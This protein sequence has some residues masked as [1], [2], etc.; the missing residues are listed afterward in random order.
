MNVTY[1]IAHLNQRQLITTYVNFPRYCPAYRSLCWLSS[2]HFNIHSLSMEG[3]VFGEFV[4]PFHCTINVRLQRGNA[5][6]NAMVIKKK[7]HCSIR[8][9]SPTGKANGRVFVWTIHRFLIRF[10][11]YYRDSLFAPR[12]NQIPSFSL[13][14]FLVRS[15]FSFCF[16]D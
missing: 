3:K 11:I 6:Q 16:D 15:F 9:T 10:N 4:E 12:G 7:T 2:R 8:T 1:T 13:L 14:Y 5:S